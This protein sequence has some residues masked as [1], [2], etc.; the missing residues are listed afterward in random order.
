MYL[1]VLS[2]L[3]KKIFVIRAP[4]SSI[5]TMTR[6][7]TLCYYG[8]S[9][10]TRRRSAYLLIDD[11]TRGTFSRSDRTKSVSAPSTVRHRRRRRRRRRSAINR[12]LQNWMI[13]LPSIDIDAR[14]LLIPRR[15]LRA[16][17]IA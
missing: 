16:D 4:F 12:P 7:E 5:F 3:L 8:D 13:P 14:S 1:C 6:V 9:C 15:N 11:T 17:S 10:G 2:I